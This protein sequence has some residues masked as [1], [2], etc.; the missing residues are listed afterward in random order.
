MRII[1][2]GTPDFAVAALEEIIKNKIEVIGVVTQ[3]DRAK[4]RGKKVQYTPVKQVAL[5][6]NIPVFQPESAKDKDF[7]QKL[8]L[9]N[10]DCIVVAAYGNILSKDLLDIPR[11]GCVNI[12]ASLLPQYRGAAPIHWAVINGDEKT[13]ITIMQMDEGLDTGDMLLKDE[14]QIGNKTTGQLHDILAEM[15]GRLIV[16]ALE[17]IQSKTTQPMKQNN[18]AA[19][20]AGMIHKKMGKI[21]WNKTADEIERLIRGLNP[22]PIAYTIYDHTIMKIWEAEVLDEISNAPYGTIVSI[23]KSGLNVAAGDKIL[24]IKKLQFPN[25]KAVT[26]DEYLRG[27]Q[28]KQNI[29][30]GLE[31]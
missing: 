5:D 11:Y 6:H 26:V 8:R 18:E 16:E 2:M 1:F 13:G 28:I 23:S 21:E 20:Y 9:L 22:W 31:G 29:R 3:P 4:G 24:Q 19:S 27:N 7:I 12:H 15:G 10:P 30:L 14:V 25:K 17:K